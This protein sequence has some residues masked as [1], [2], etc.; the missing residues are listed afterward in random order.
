MGKKR[1]HVF[2]EPIVRHWCR[3]SM[4]RVLENL[5]TNAQKYGYP[6]APIKVRVQRE[7]TSMLLSVQNEGT[8]IPKAEMDLMFTPY[9]RIEDT[10][11]TGGDL[12]CRTSR[13]SPVHT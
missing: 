5:L 9:H 4:K 7:D 13:M 1:V 11:V 8:P 6:S 12:V 2:G 3:V 10:H